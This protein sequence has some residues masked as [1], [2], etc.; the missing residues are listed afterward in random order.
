MA[1]QVSICVRVRPKLFGQAGYHWTK[2]GAS[3]LPAIK[4]CIDN[5][6]WPGILD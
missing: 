4:F 5:N 2:A 1:T 3:A 6:R